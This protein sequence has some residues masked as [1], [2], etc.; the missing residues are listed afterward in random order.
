M[1]LKHPI[2]TRLA[3]AAPFGAFA[4]AL[5]MQA[6]TSAQN[7]AVQS[8]IASGVAAG[9]RYCAMASA[10]GPIVVQIIATTD[11][12]AADALN[13]AGVIVA[14]SCAAINAVPTAAPPTS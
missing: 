4:L 9:K 14:D 2:L 6:C 5:T 12:K 13:T 11:P 1:T 3:I 10:L 7:A 8:D